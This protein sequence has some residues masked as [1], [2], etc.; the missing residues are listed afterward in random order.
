LAQKI[1]LTSNKYDDF[2]P[3]YVACISFATLINLLFQSIMAGAHLAPMLAL[4]VLKN[5]A[6]QSVW[7]Q[8]SP[9]DV[10]FTPDGDLLYTENC[11]GLSLVSTDGQQAK[12]LDDSVDGL[13]PDFFCDGLSGMNGVVV[14]PDFGVDGSPYR[15]DVY[16]FFLS[17]M[18]TQRPS[19]RVARI[20]L[21][22]NIVDPPARRVDI[23][24]GIMYKNDQFEQGT[25]VGNGGSAV[26]GAMGSGR[27]RFG[28][29]GTQYEVFTP[30]LKTA[31]SW[32]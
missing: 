14:D 16:V 23:M 4:A 8:N 5:A 1:E 30:L 7:S 21:A 10:A 11:H 26:T 17:S 19:N 22:P 13:A 29:R 31:P 24:R 28:L 27:L 2:P 18:D 12:L 32:Q 9:W 25:T 6:A 20:T 15:R 3:I